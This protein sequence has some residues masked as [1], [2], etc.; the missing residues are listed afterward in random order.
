MFQAS[1]FHLD[2]DVVE[3]QTFDLYDGKVCI[4][5]PGQFPVP[6]NGGLELGFNNLLRLKVRRLWYR[7][8]QRF[9]GGFLWEICRAF[10]RYAHFLIGGC[11][12]QAFVRDGSFP[13]SVSVERPS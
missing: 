1:N 4:L 6:M 7:C 9:L 12:S 2:V 5:V 11:F 3:M 13:G 8:Y 10:L